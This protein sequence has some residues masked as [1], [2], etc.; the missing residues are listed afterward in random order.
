[1][2]D[3]SQ[4]NRDMYDQPVKD[5]FASILGGLAKIFVAEMVEIGQSILFTP[6]SYTM[7]AIRTDITAK[8]IQEERGDKGPLTPEL[9][10]LAKA[11]MEDTGLKGKKGTFRR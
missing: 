10:R 3:E 4:L 1:M 2:T 7:V 11:R 5:D 8:D 6:R 9:L